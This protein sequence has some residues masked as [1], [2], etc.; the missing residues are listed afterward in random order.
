MNNLHQLPFE[1]PS[2]TNSIRYPAQVEIL[3]K[4]VH[5]DLEAIE[6]TLKYLSSEID[7]LRFLMISAIHDWPHTHLWQKLMR[8]LGMHR[9]P[10]DDSD[11]GLPYSRMGEPA[12]VRR[13]D[14]S[15]VAV[16]TVDES[17]AEKNAKEVVLRLGLANPL[18]A[19]RFAAAYLQGLRGDLSSLPFLEKVIELG[20]PLWKRRAVEALA[21]LNHADCASSLMQALGDPDKSVHRA[22]AHALE[23]LGR[24]AIPVL[25]QSLE[26]PDRHVRWHVARLLGAA[27]D[28]RAVDVLASGLTDPDASV[29]WASASSLAALGK[30]AVQAVLEIIRTHE[31]SEDL[32]QA[33]YH[34]LHALPADCREKLKLLI[35]ALSSPATA[36]QAP[37]IA[38]RLILE[39]KC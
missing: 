12:A 15:I 11:A 37:A 9:W 31:L 26:Q 29:R 14:Q 17:L 38:S 18:A 10:L 13:L 36:V 33:V 22:A 32:R 6:I 24:K 2:I 30:P 28:P 25:I 1:Y 4:A 5:G 16:F 21:A 35:E 23:G 27:G 3:Q 39:V 7:N 34:A 20:D 8:F 19:I